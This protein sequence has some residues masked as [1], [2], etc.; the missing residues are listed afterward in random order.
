METAPRRCRR[1]H[2]RF[3]R[4]RLEEAKSALEATAKQ[5]GFS[6][7]Q[8]IGQTPAKTDRRTRTVAPKYADPANPDTTWSGRGRKPKWVEA[9]LASGKTLDDLKI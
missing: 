3:E 6:L 2:L 7:D 1:R 4:R 5:F 8:V 9:Y